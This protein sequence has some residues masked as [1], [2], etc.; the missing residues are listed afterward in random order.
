MTNNSNY[1]CFHYHYKKVCHHTELLSFKD[2]QFCNKVNFINSATTLLSA[3]YMSNK[4][5]IQLN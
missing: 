5:L 4:G 1:S 3:Y 2:G